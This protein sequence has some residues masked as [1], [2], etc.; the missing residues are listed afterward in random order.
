MS[1]THSDTASHKSSAT[2]KTPVLKRCVECR[3]LVSINSSRNVCETCKEIRLGEKIRCNCENKYF[4]SYRPATMSQQSCIMCAVRGIT[5]VKSDKYKKMIAEY[6]I[7]SDG[8]DMPHIINV[9]CRYCASVNYKPNTLKPSIVLNKSII[10]ESSSRP[11]IDLSSFIQTEPSNK[12]VFSTSTSIPDSTLIVPK[13]P[14]M[15]I[16]ST[17]ACFTAEV[18]TKLRD[19]VGA[20]Q[21]QSFVVVFVDPSDKRSVNDV[22][23]SI[24][25]I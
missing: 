20:S 4:H 12:K 21:G 15:S 11:I 19:S 7:C 23:R 10:P 24:Q 1:Q 8:C 25:Q 22:I 16:L 9:S 14:T 6:E 3:T 2:R 18:V 17:S 13:M 5:S